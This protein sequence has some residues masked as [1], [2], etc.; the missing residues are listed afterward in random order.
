M[1]LFTAAILLILLLSPSVAFAEW[2]T[3]NGVSYEFTQMGNLYRFRGT[4]S[5]SSNPNCL[6]HIF[7]DFDHLINFITRAD[8]TILL[9][10]GRNSYEVCYVYRKLLFKSKFTYRKRLMQKEKRITFEMVSNE[11]S[12]LSFPK[13]LSSKGCYEIKHQA[14]GYTIVY[15][16]EARIGSKLPCGA[17]SMAKKEAIRFLEGLKEHVERKCY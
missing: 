17:V 2:Q 11:Q 16:E 10:Q 14:E 13:V 6:L 5:T 3:L 8:S 1:K 12:L 9:H 7:Y 4:F 15:F